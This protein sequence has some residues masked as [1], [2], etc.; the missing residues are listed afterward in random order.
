MAPSKK[1]TCPHL[2]GCEY[3]TNRKNDLSK[4]VST[5]TKHRQCT[6]HCPFYN[7]VANRQVKVETP[8]TFATKQAKRQNSSPTPDP[9]TLNLN[10]LCVLDPTRRVSSYDDTDF[11]VS[12]LTAS[13][14]PTTKVKEVLTCPGLEGYVFP[15]PEDKNAVRIYEWVSYV[16]LTLMR[17]L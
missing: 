9:S 16:H 8:H 11:D 1:H 2:C 5:G 3:S 7:D 14:I 12:W 17:V 10:L 13:D 6:P 15:D 4:H